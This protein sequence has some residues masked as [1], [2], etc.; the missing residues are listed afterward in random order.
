MSVYFRD[1]ITYTTQIS[2]IGARSFLLLHRLRS[3]LFNNH[4][5]LP[6]LQIPIQDTFVNVVYPLRDHPHSLK[7]LH[8]IINHLW[9][10]L[11]HHLNVTIVEPMMVF[12]NVAIV[13]NV[14]AFN[15]VTNTTKTSLLN[16][17]VYMS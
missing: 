9:T 17:N 4:L 8:R 3:L 5:N 10:L 15:A 6:Y 7:C 11:P 12:F 2:I 14:Y 16:S 13:T 1:S